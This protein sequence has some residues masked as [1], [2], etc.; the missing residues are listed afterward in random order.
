MK[1]D[2]EEDEGQ[3]FTERLKTLRN[4]AIDLTK[5]IEAQNIKLRQLEPSFQSSLNKIF[6]TIQSIRRS[7]PKRFRSWLYFILG[8]MGLSFLFFILF[9][10]S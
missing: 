8:G 10:A 9:I 6:T 5:E 3:I 7:D 1:Y 4:V 2:Y